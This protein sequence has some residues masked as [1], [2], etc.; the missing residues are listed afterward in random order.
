MNIINYQK[1][2]RSDEKN[3][4]KRKIKQA[5]DGREGKSERVRKI[6]STAN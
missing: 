4:K 3:L 2:S 1:P 6:I 5:S